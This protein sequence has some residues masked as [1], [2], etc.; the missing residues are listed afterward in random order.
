MIESNVEIVECGFLTDSI[1][2]E[3]DKSK[4]T[5]LSQLEDI[6]PENREN[7]LFV[8]MVNYGD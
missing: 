5:D 8:L 7:K 3:R 6:I 4:F 1:N 2:Y